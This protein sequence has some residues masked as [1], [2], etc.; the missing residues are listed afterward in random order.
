MKFENSVVFFKNI[1]KYKKYLRKREKPG[2]RVPSRVR[3]I[4][5][6]IGNCIKIQKFNCFISFVTISLS[7]LLN[8]V[9]YCFIETL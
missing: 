5:V 3:K 7:K 6:Q 1:G 4:I 8:P 2:W 9:G